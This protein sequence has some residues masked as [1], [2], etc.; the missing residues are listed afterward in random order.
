MILCLFLSNVA[1]TIITSPPSNVSALVG[2][3]I[4]L[5]CTAHGLPK[6]LVTWHKQCSESNLTSIEA[7]HETYDS[8]ASGVYEVVSIIGLID[9]DHKDGCYYYCHVTNNATIVKNSDTARAFV[10]IQ[11]ESF[12]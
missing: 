9:V 2:Q 7:L 5:S 10:T 12:T 4:T 3:N 8:F 1:P 11:S 6:P